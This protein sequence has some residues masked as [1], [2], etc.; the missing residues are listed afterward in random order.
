M[1]TALPKED[2][3]SIDPH[4][5]LTGKIVQLETATETM[6]AYIGYLSTQIL[7]EEVQPVPNQNRIKAL[8]EQ[9]RTISKERREIMPDNGRLIAKALYVY[10]PIMKALYSAE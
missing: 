5:T 10:A 1:N 6:M 7:N 4:E 8:E 9:M 2:N 3:Y